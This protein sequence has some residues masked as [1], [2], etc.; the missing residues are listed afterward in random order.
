MDK[1]HS[2]REKSTLIGDLL[3]QPAR[4][5][6]ERQQARQYREKL[7]FITPSSAGG[8]GYGGGGG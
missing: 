4:L 8:Q 3:T 7:G 6:E 5:E 1:G 2:I